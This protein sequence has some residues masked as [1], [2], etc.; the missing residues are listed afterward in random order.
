MGNW[1]PINQQVNIIDNIGS[2]L[3]IVLQCP[4]RYVEPHYGKPMFE[5]KC[6]KTFPMFVVEPAYRTKKWKPIIQLH[7]ENQ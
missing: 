2:T 7:N 1:Q 5:C 4:V 6:L 3:S